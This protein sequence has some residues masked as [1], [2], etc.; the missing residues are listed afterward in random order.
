MVREALEFWVSDPA[1]VYMDLT[2]GCGGHSEALLAK[3]PQARGIGVDWDHESLAIARERLAPW[4]SRI[5][6]RQGNFC[7]IGEILTQIG[8]SRV[9]GF[10]FD[11]GPSTFQI[12][13]ASRGLS[14]Q[15]DEPLDMRMG[16]TEASLSAAELLESL[17]NRELESLLMEF[18]EIPGGLARRLA[19]SILRNRPKTSGD[20]TRVLSDVTSH[21]GLWARCFAALRIVVN[22][23]MDNL[24]RLL[25]IMPD[26]LAPGGR[27]VGI[28]FHSLED[29]RVKNSF[30]KACAGGVLKLLTKKPIRA[31]PDEIRANPKARSCLL[32]VAEKI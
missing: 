8:I 26:F 18:G 25:K 13:H 31:A 24:E 5:N 1:G 19:G 14:Y 21:R 6:L 23:E 27:I 11:L 12:L 20:L 30:R 9:N 3:H 7:R 4:G 10:L 16:P 2:L 29:R 28:S 15:K 17:S 32:R 22:R